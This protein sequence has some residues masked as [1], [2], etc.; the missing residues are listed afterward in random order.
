[1]RYGLLNDVRKLDK[2]AYPLMVQRF[3]A[4][5]LPADAP[6]PVY[7]KAPHL[8]VSEDARRGLDCHGL[9]TD[10]PVLGCALRSLASSAGRNITMQRWRSTGSITVVRCGSSVLP[11]ISRWR[12][13]SSIP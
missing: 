2:D 9:N 4:L 13:P 11:R 6:V 1:M 12:I 7:I 10:K 8:D 3:V 5:A